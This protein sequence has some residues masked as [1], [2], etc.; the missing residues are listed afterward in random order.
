MNDGSCLIMM[1][2]Y[3]GERFIREQIE[4]IIGQTYTDWELVIQDDGSR[5]DTVNIINRY[6]EREPRIRLL[7]N[8]S[9]NHGPYQNFNVLVNRCRRETPRDYYLFADQDD[10]WDSD[11]LARLTE[12]YRRSQK[13][14]SV[15]ML[16]YGDMRLM[17]GNGSVTGE[18]LDRIDHIRR[19]PLSMFFDASVWG[20]NFFF[21]RA[22]FMD[23]K[24]VA[25]DSE[26]VWGHDQ[27]FARWA[28][29]RGKVLFYDIPLMSYRRYAGSVTDAHPVNVSRNRVL[30]RMRE[31]DKLAYDHAVMYKSA[32]FVTDK[33]EETELT[34]G[35][36]QMVYG[37]KSCINRGGIY[38]LIYFIRNKINLGR[39]IRTMS[40]LFILIT[41]KYKKHLKE[42]V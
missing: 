25:D 12:Y 5:D 18:S 13:D 42:I 27:Y 15:P 29:V 23:V 41:G 2:S 32:L 6:A 34:P 16:I 14:D 1:A 21:N 3:N 22:L 35:Q 19:T 38:A 24:E 7:T 11:K 30:E 31:I 36:K 28:A 33:L 8:D 4:S 20:C 9:G 37:I 10:I 40:H 26:R 17:D 39:N